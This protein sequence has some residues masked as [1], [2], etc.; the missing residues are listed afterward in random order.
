MT[1]AAVRAALGALVAGAGVLLIV[2]GI[3]AGVYQV[4]EHDWIVYYEN[5]APYGAFMIPL[6][7][8]GAAL[9]IAGV[10]LGLRNRKRATE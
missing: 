1:R 10:T 3:I 4:K 8:V 9:V 5:T 2:L 6:L 7:A